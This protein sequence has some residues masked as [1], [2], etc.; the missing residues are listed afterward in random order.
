LI[1]EDSNVNGNPV[2]PQHGPGPAEA[3][4]AF[5]PAHPAF[6]R[7]VSREKFLLTYNPGGFLRR[8]K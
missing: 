3:I 2:P 1:V 6:G 5:L 4:A 8:M 7:D